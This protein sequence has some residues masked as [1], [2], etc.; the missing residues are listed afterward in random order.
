MHVI[1][2]TKRKK[3]KKKSF[4][5]INNTQSLFQRRKE[6][7]RKK[8]D[9]FTKRILPI[10][11]L[12]EILSRV[13]KSIADTAMARVNKVKDQPQ[14]GVESRSR[15]LSARFPSSS[16]SQTV[17]SSE[18]ALLIFLRHFKIS[19]EKFKKDTRFSVKYN[20]IEKSKL[21]CNL[22]FL[23]FPHMFSHG[24]INSES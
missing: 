22:I 4:L 17:R 12:F 19:T 16:Q 18:R 7:K 20:A 5:N 15:F 1:I 11:Q 8:K 9:K 6:K 14:P 23:L 3:L 13:H 24:Y 21:I 10:L 2:E